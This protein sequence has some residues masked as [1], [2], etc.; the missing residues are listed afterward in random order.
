MEQAFVALGSNHEPRLY[1]LR[2]AARTL[3]ANDGIRAYRLSPLYY[4]D[5]L[6]CPEPRPFLNAVL[7][8]QTTWSPHELLSL[9]LDVETRLG[10]ERPYPN[11][12]RTIDLDLILYGD[13]LIDE[14]PRLVLP[15]PRAHERAFVLRPLLDLEPNAVWPTHNTLVAQLLAQTRDAPPRLAVSAKWPNDLVAGQAPLFPRSG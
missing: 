3:T 8:I 15:H 1:W 4:S 6:D 12:P 9:L 10:R 5:A 14:P 13:R 2:E 11:A 7:C